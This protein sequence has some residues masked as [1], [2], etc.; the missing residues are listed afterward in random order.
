MTQPVGASQL[1]HQPP[2]YWH[3]GVMNGEGMVR[4]ES[5][6]WAQQHDLLLT[7]VSLTTPMAK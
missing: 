3:N 2:Q 5:Y 7:K 4:E 6:T 1:F